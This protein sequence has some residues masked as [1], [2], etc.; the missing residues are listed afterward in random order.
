MALAP[1]GVVWA[2]TTVGVFSF[3]G[4][5]WVWRFPGSAGGIWVAGD[6]TVWVAGAWGLARVD[7]DAWVVA[8][9]DPGLRPAQG[10]PV[11]LAVAADG[12]VWMAGHSRG[13]PPLR[14]DGA[15][16]EEVPIGGGAGDP[17]WIPCGFRRWRRRPTATSG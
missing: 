5:D 14:H 2:A 11:R 17:V 1:D 3:A 4:A 7:G 8:D 15:A 9:S 6:G 12:T 16:L 10:K 13:G